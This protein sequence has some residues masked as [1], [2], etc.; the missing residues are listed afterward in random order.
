MESTVTGQEGWVRFGERPAETLHLDTAEALLTLWRE[1]HPH[2]FGA[3][4]AEVL[5]GERF[6]KARPR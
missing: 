4:L 2:Q 5:T 3:L 6:T 1:R